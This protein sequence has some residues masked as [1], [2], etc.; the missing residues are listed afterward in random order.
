M[1]FD[2]TIITTNT[3]AIPAQMCRMKIK[4]FQCISLLIKVVVENVTRLLRCQESLFRFILDLI[5]VE[6]HILLALICS[7]V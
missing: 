5:L 7:C 3:M 4:V 1:E 2:N 6:R